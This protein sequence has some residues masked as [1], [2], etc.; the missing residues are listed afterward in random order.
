MLRGRTIT[1][2]AMILVAGCSSMPPEPLPSATIT[3]PETSVAPV[4]SPSGG[5]DPAVIVG[6]PEL[7]AI[8]IV[9]KALLHEPT[10][11]V[12]QGQRFEVREVSAVAGESFGGSGRYA[13]VLIEFAEALAPDAWPDEA[14]C[15]IG[16]RS[17]DI[18]GIAWL[19]SLDTTEV[20]AY[21]PQW[22]ESIDCVPSGP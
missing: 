18:T 5:V 21:S 20:S 11:N 2:T 12:H 16:R 10:S 3:G 1:L 4:T 6:V 22:D 14:V 13:R 7:I 9:E 19:I 8:E 17:E 15:A